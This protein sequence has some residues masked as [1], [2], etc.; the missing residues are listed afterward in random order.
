MVSEVKTGLSLLD[1]LAKKVV[2]LILSALP[3][4]KMKDA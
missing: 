3:E 2:R 4:G 1:D